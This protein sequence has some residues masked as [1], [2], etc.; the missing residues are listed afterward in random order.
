MRNLRVLLKHLSL[1]FL[2]RHPGRALLLVFSVSLGVAAVM[3]SATL[4]RSATA[5]IENTWQASAGRADLRI[6]NGFVGVPEELA[7][8]V[9]RSAG[10]ANATSIVAT[11]ARAKIGPEPVD[12]MIVGIDLLVEDPIHT[13]SGAYGRDQVEVADEM[14]F[15]VRPN[16]IAAMAPAV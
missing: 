10:V 7:D 5:S 14:D 6:A 13:G 2:R 8:L 16:A 9:R 12:L 3:A 4:I 11:T 15:L 1:P